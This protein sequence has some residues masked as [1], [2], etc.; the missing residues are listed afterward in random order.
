M[1]QPKRN[2]RRAHHGRGVVESARLLQITDAPD[3]VEDRRRNEQQ[4]RRS[5]RTGSTADCGRR[6]PSR[7]PRPSAS[8]RAGPRASVSGSRKKSS[9]LIAR[10]PMPMPIQNVFQATPPAIIGPTTNWPA[11]PPAMPNIC[12]APINVAARERESSSSRCR[13]RRRARRRRRRPAGAARCWRPRCCPIANSSAPMP[14][15]AA[16]IGTTFRGPSRS[17][18]HAGDE[19]E[20][21]VAVVEEADHRGD[22][23]S[24]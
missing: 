11:E 9:T 22:A 5:S 21:R 4:A 12:V 6:C 2:R 13:P 16:P 17:M 18:R 15:I 3:H 1:I 7:V 23:Q 24:R 20:R 19:T 14:T 10:P 8:R